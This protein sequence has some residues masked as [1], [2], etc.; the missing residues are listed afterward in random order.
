MH[1]A[2]V[3]DVAACK[4]VMPVSS[5][6]KSCSG[7]WDINIPPSSCAVGPETVYQHGYF[8]CQICTRYSCRIHIPDLLLSLTLL[9]VVALNLQ[10]GLCHISSVSDGKVKDINALFRANQIVKAKVGI[11]V[12]CPLFR[13]CCCLVFDDREPL[14]VYHVVSLNRCSRYQSQASSLVVHQLFIMYFRAYSCTRP[15][16]P[17]FCR[18]ELNL[19][20]FACMQTC[21]AT[22]LKTNMI[23]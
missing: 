19:F 1:R 22:S 16:L 13:S 10:S 4:K 7:A 3:D 21:V 5:F 14:V 9:S 2:W 18:I 20:W 12:Y 11:F 17:F 15:A 8:A 23:P 6:V